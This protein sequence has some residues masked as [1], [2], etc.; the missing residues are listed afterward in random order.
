MILIIGGALVIVIGVEMIK[1][2]FRS[3]SQRKDEE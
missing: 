2:G 1:A 3:I